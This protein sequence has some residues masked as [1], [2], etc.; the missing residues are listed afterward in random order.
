[1]LANCHLNTSSIDAVAVSH[2]LRWL[3]VG[4]KADRNI[5]LI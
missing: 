5:V 3:A 2:S 1:M 4:S